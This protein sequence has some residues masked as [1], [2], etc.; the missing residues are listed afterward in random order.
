MIYHSSVIYSELFDVYLGVTFI[1]TNAYNQ[2]CF[3]LHL[4]I[5]GNCSTVEENITTNMVH[6]LGHYNLKF[7]QICTTTSANNILHKFY[8]TRLVVR[9]FCFFVLFCFLFF[10]LLLIKKLHGSLWIE[11]NCIKAWEPLLGNSLL[12]TTPSPGFSGTHLIY[13][14]RLK[15]CNKNDLKQITQKFYTTIFKTWKTRKE[16]KQRT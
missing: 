4:H 1:L 3:S 15:S 11:F 5:Y 9:F 13:L 10:L 8:Q 2:L 7:I 16:Y 6:W 14:E 12:L